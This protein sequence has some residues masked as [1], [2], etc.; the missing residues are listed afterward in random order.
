MSEE[1]KKH[2][3]DYADPEEEAKV[4]TTGLKDIA[5]VKGT[6]NEVCIYK[7]RAKLYRFRDN[8][9]KE[10]GV[11]HAKLMRHKETK[12]I[13]F[14]MRQEKTKKP[15]GNFLLTEDPLCKIESM[16]ETGKAYLWSCQDCSDEAE[17]TLEKMSIRFN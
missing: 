17:G 7:E 15:I 6:E 2:D 9:W 16:G 11:G 4:Q 12:K 5:V 13:R 14:V 8:Q 1:E 10:R 3:V